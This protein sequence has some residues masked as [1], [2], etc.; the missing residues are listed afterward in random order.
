MAAKDERGPLRR[1][2]DEAAPRAEAPWRRPIRG[3]ADWPAPRGA[4]PTSSG[5]PK[6]GQFPRNPP[7]RPGVGAARGGRSHTR[8]RGGGRAAPAARRAPRG[9]LNPHASRRAPGKSARGGRDLQPGALM[10]ELGHGETG[11]AIGRRLVP[12]TD[13]ASK[14]VLENAANE[15]LETVDGWSEPWAARRRD[16]A[17]ECSAGV[18]KRQVGAGSPCCPP[19]RTGRSE[20]CWSDPHHRRYPRQ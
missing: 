2:R 15:E 19:E 9:R 16:C 3:A 1:S 5:S 11:P 12:G 4:G 20:L 18:M 13:D 10:N 6:A 7:T 17:G 8:A 14:P